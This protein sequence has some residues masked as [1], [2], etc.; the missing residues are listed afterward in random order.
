MLQKLNRFSEKFI[1]DREKMLQDDVSRQRVFINSSLLAA[2]FSF[3][4]IGMTLLIGY[5]IGSIGLAISGL[6]FLSFPLLLRLKVPYLILANIFIAVLLVSLVVYIST[7]GGL[8]IAVVAPWLVFITCIAVLFLNIRYALGWTI[9]TA[10]TAV[11]LLV[12]ENNDV[13][14][15]I[16]FDTAYDPLY[17][18]IVWVGLLFL[19]LLVISVFKY[20]EDHARKMLAEKNIELEKAMRK[21]KK[22]QEQLIESEKL[23]SLG[24]VTAGIA[25]EIQ[26]PMNFIKN[27]SELSMEL[28]DEA[29]EEDSPEDQREL[30]DLIRQNL[31]KIG[32]HSR[33]TDRIVKNMLDHAHMHGN[34]RILTSL[35]SLCH[36]IMQVTLQSLNIR[37]SLPLLSV[38]TDF[39]PADP[40]C[41]IMPADTGRILVNLLNNAVYSL[42]QKARQFPD[43]H[44]V[45]HLST[46]LE[47]EHVILRIKDNGAGIPPQIQKDIFRPFFTTK[48]T[49]EGT[50]LGLSLSNTIMQAQDGLIE[51]ESS[52]EQFTVFKLV[53]KQEIQS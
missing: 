42:Q 29:S 20:S 38:Q 18:G 26:N 41:S 14:M 17:R 45:I 1:P 34:E 33:R 9:A 25:H 48:P 23:A 50:G 11:A 53:F 35:N 10:L 30:F 32:E 15:P 27:F 36:D 21:L 46:S 22:T 40:Q 51:L 44:P 12:L 31:Q 47:D 2:V 16:R 43:F 24:Q 49:G 7:Q 52:N 5:S 19:V 39:H 4:Y 37:E 28:I 13:P 3:G 6:L 8:R